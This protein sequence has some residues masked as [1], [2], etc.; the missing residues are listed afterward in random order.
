MMTDYQ[1]FII[2]CI[3]MA[4]LVAASI[5]GLWNWRV[6]RWPYRVIVAWLCILTINLSVIAYGAFT[7]GF[8]P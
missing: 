8:G 5:W 7:G 1:V 3:L 2:F 4:V 6:A